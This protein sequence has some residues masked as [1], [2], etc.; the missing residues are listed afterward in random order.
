MN[1][2][3]SKLEHYNVSAVNDGQPGPLELPEDVENVLKA[4]EQELGELDWKKAEGLL[5]D[6]LKIRKH[7]MVGHI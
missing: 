2:L 7:A 1:M 5:R 6:G 3:Q 4:G